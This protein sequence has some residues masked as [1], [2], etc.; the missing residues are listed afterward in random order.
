MI[1]LTLPRPLSIMEFG[2]PIVDGGI[3]KS[4]VP[5]WGESRRVAVQGVWTG[6]VWHPSTKAVLRQY[7]GTTLVGVWQVVGVDIPSR[8]N[9]DAVLLLEPEGHVLAPQEDD[10]TVFGE[11]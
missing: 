7:R 1:G 9:S 8:Q 3:I 11:G 5:V 4:S 10:I 2:M 6:G